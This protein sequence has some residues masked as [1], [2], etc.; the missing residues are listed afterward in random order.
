MKDRSVTKTHLQIMNIYSIILDML[1][2]DLNVFVNEDG[3]ENKLTEVDYV[4]KTV[5]PAMDIIFSDVNH[6]IGLQCPKSGSKYGLGGVASV[7]EQNLRT[8][9]SILD[10]YLISDKAAEDS[11]IY[12]FQFAGLHGQL[13]ADDGLYFSLDG[14]T[15][16]FPFRLL[17]IK[18]MR[19]TLGILYFFKKNIM[20]KSSAL[21]RY[22]VEK[23]PYQKVFHS[24]VLLCTDIITEFNRVIE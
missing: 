22:D 16:K 9:K 3:K 8:N 15:F 14:S 10:D 4:L 17:N 18:T 12:T 13:I 11:A 1:L 24:R 20:Q 2:N 6:I 19:Q 5:A 23:N 7:I 21:S